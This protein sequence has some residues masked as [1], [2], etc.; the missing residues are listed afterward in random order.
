MTRKW[1]RVKWP[2]NH[3]PPYCDWEC[4]QLKISGGVIIL[5]P[6]SWPTEGW[7]YVQ[8]CGA[9][10]DRSHSGFLKG[11]VK[12]ELAKQQIEKLIQEG[13]FD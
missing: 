5:H 10:S 4:W 6:G 13:K 11:Y 3:E 7:S 12:L 2:F 9:N 8:D 1:K